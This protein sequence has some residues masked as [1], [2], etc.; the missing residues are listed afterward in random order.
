MASPDLPPPTSHAPPEVPLGVML[1]LTIPY[2][3][4]LPELV[5]AARGLPAEGEGPG[6]AHSLGTRAPWGQGHSR[7][8]LGPAPPLL[9]LSP[10]VP[11]PSLCSSQFQQYGG[12]P[13]QTQGD[14]QA[15]W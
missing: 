11:N 3:F 9:R 4:F 1:F 7:A 15:T 14:S 6:E 8:A 2:A 12:F 13:K 5:S 10:T